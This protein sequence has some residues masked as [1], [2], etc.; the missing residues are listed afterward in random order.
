[1][2]ITP[3]YELKTRL[4]AAMI[5]G[6]NLLS[7]DFRLKK[8]AEG[9]AALSGSS[10][11]FAKINAMT[12]R[13]L[14]E[15]SPECLLDTITLVDAVITTLGTAEVKGELVDLPDNGGSAVIVNAPY[16]RLSA[17]LDALT[18]SGGGQYNAFMEVKNN[19]P[20]LLNDYRVKPALVKGLGASYSELAEEVAS[21]LT[22][23]GKD[24]LP[25]LK[26]GFDPKGKKDMLRRVEVIE[27]L[28]GEEENKFYL[29]QLENA[30]KDIRKALIYALRHDESNIER[31]IEL[32]KTEKGKSKT[33]ALYALASFDNEKAAAFIEEYA[34]KKPL[35][36]IDI[37]EQTSS[38]WSSKLTAR[39]I[40]EL[41]VDDKGNKITLSQ[42]ANVEKIKLG[43]KTDF[44]HLN[45]AMFGKFGED[46][47]KIYREFDNKD[48]FIPMDVRL[49]DA[50]LETGDEGLKALALEL[51]AGKKTK[52]GY[53][54]SE[55]VVRLLGKEDCSKWVEEQV[56][57]VDKK[58]YAK[59]NEMF[60][61]PIIKAIRLIALKDGKFVLT[62]QHYD[63]MKDRWRYTVSIPTEYPVRETLTDIL[64]KY[65]SI[66]DSMIAAWADPE[67]RAY[68]QKL[69]DAFVEHAVS[70]SSTYAGSLTYLNK[71]GII[72]IKGLALQF[73]KNHNDYNKWAVT[74][75]FN[76]LPG[77]NEYKLA[78]ARELIELWRSGK[79]KTAM[80]ENDINYFA[81]W[82]ETRFA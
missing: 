66:F 46:I 59:S 62:Q 31:L 14:S 5:A 38:E 61:T 20:E 49:G 78:E 35:E 72:N 32:A 24:M 8:A 67:D 18:T 71:L 10:P 63:V 80:S 64:I 9:F 41:L 79:L 57:K 30:E 26:R 68:C 77:D 34:K 82:A 29:E 27:S 21:T 22:D 45:S 53:V 56:R 54:Y 6:T 42:A 36:V 11:V 70:K 44:W 1:M 74:G 17:V 39:L 52:G 60:N 75:F 55:A 3:V 12:E 28:G 65:P 40:D 2:D 4:R 43:S 50:I 19:D 13:L 47:E 81:E 23:M 15:K 58:V 69:A 37:M 76:I 16:S 51:N 73:C 48:K 33:A 25:L 7:E